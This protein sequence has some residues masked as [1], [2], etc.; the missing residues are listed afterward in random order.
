MT[1]RAAA[2]ERTADRILDATLALWSRTPYDR[3]RLD[4]VATDAGVTVQ[5]VIRRFGGKPGLVTAMANRALE[6]IA[7]GRADRA[8]DAPD[9][10]IADL[11][12]HYERY[13]AAI[14][15]L[16]AEADAAPGLAE[17]ARRGRD[18]H[19]A[20]CASAFA[21]LLEA[22]PDPEDRARRRAQ[23]VVVCDATTWR[24]LREEAGLSPGQV[25]QALA[26][27]LAPLLVPPGPVPPAPAR[28]RGVPA[29]P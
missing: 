24:I 27:L 16:Y 9:R 14:L 4:Q 29:R 13:G 7:A 6:G 12:A 17:V 20:W 5:T 8:G 15:K 10:L 25:E 22:V 11:V 19:L 26:E 21:D 28:T 3:L 18:H 2:A 23:L 1:G